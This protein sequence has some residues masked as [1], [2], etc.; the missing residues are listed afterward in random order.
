MADRYQLGG[1]G[2]EEWALPELVGGGY[3]RAGGRVP[4][5]EALPSVV[6]ENDDVIGRTPISHLTSS[7]KRYAEMMGQGMPGTKVS[8][9]EE[10]LSR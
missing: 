5:D 7:S 10:R 4:D 3:G 6:S 2:R 8:T 9:R 1:H